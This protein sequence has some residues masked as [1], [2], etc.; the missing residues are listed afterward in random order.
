MKIRPSVFTRI[1]AGINNLLK[2]LVFETQ[3]FVIFMARAAGCLCRKPRYWND[4]FDHM[5]IMGVASIPIVLISGACVGALITLDTLAELRLFGAH[6]LLGKLTGLSIIRGFG[7]VLTAMIVSSRICSSAAA[8]LG[9]MQASQQIDALTT[10]GID[11]F[12]KLITPR[13]LAGLFMFPA[14]SIINAVA[15]ILAGGLVALFS[16]TMSFPF[17]INQSLSGISPGDVLWGQTKSAVFGFVVVSVACH[18]GLRV[19]GGTAGV[20][21]GASQAAVAGVL[22]ILISDFI[23]TS[24]VHSF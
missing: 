11:H 1:V 7:P 24:F 20:R 5:D 3:E 22:L 23:M 21:K 18:Y 4:F 12:A 19:S 15:A 6:V 8:E 13:I 14:L 2:F 16:G 10:M 9:S 17:F